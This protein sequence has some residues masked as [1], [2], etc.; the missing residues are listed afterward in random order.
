VQTKLGCVLCSA[1]ATTVPCSALAQIVHNIQHLVRCYRDPVCPACTPS[2][3]EVLQYP[4][5]SPSPVVRR[6][7]R[8]RRVI[9][10]TTEEDIDEEM[11][12][13]PD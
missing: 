2:I 3:S 4:S 13:A 5:T 8:H 6:A 1:G 11:G 10:D 7:P 12:E 9:S